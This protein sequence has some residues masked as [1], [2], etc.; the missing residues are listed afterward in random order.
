MIIHTHYLNFQRRMHFPKV[1]IFIKNCKEFG[2]ISCPPLQVKNTFI[3]FVYAVMQLMK[4]SDS[5][6]NLSTTHVIYSFQSTLSYYLD[7]ITIM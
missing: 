4:V 7:L 3:I 6:E 5:I 2:S 1:N